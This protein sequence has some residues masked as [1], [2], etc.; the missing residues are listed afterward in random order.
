MLEAIA[1]APA[2]SGGVTGNWED[3]KWEVV[4]VKDD[5][6]NVMGKGAREWVRWCKGFAKDPV[7]G[8]KK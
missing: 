2:Q 5:L 1:W 8:G 3:E 7:K 6:R 4:E